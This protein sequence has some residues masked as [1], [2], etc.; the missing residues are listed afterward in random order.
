M[1]YILIILTFYSFKSYK[2]QT[3]Q[4]SIYNFSDNIKF[5]IIFDTLLITVNH[6]N[7]LNHESILKEN[8][9]RSFMVKG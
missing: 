6:M 2:N 8:F 4:I 7:H 9:F 1:K 5:E 3:I